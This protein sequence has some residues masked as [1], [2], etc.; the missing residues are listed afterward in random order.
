MQF[1]RK[2]LERAKKGVVGCLRR[3]NGDEIEGRGAGSELGV[4]KCMG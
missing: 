1:K 4:G 3:R 2:Y